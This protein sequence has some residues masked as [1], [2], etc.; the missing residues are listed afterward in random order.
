VLYIEDTLANVQVVE[1]I[2][3][4]PPS[5]RLIPAMLGQLGL[6]LAREHRPDLILVDLHLPDL[7][8]E[9]VL[10]ELR[11]DSATRHTPVV[12]LSADATRDRKQMLVGGAR[13]YLTKPIVLRRLLETLDQFLTETPTDHPA[14]PVVG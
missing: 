11:A 12:I 13:A 4:R 5:I 1:G 14:Q 6:D 2:L 7:P 3:E 9:R 10:V 8:G